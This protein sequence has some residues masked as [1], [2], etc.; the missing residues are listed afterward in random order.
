MASRTTRDDVHQSYP[1]HGVWRPLSTSICH[2]SSSFL[3][4]LTIRL[5]SPL[6]PH[7]A[8][9]RSL[10]ICKWNFWISNLTK[11]YIRRNINAFVI[12]FHPFEHGLSF[13][14]VYWRRRISLVISVKCSAQ[15]EGQVPCGEGFAYGSEREVV[16]WRTMGACC[17]RRKTIHRINKLVIS[18]RLHMYIG[19]LTLNI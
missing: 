4:S 10:Y 13:V 17:F 8:L 14:G 16:D 2:E 6:R 7:I 5:S 3:M 11:W 15:I 1:S 18:M 19:G 9:P 12:L